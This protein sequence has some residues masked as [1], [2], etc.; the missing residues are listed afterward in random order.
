MELDPVPAFVS[1][2]TV[3]SG[4]VGYLPL[5]SR[6]LLV[7]RLIWPNER[8]QPLFSLQIGFELSVAST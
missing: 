1:E 4:R 5:Q 8:F 6:R 3:E 2:L 7:F